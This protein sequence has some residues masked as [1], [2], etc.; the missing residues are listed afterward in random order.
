[1]GMMYAEGGYPRTNSVQLE[2]Y[3]SRITDVE[4]VRGTGGGEGG[5][6]VVERMAPSI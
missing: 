2:K 3:L 5:T 6:Q 1:M 4:M